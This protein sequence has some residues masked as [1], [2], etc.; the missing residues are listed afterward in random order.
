MCNNSFANDC[1][2]RIQKKTAASVQFD[3]PVRSQ[4][5]SQH[6]QYLF[7]HSQMQPCV[8]VL[9]KFRM[10]Q[11]DKQ[12]VRRTLVILRIAFATENTSTSEQNFQ[13]VQV[14]ER[15]PSAAC[16]HQNMDT[17]ISQQETFLE[18]RSC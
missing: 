15:A 12:T 1:H 11:T 4:D 5:A 10:K 9:G 16:C 6:Y 7:K 8:W 14:Q 2:D 18:L 3:I 13:V 17:S